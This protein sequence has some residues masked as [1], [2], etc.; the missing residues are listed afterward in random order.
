V[1]QLESM[2]LLQAEG[3]SKLFGELK[4]LQGVDLEVKTG[5][6]HALLGHP[7]AGK[8]TLLNV[9]GGVYAPDSGRLLLEGK[10]VNFS[11]PDDAL[12]AGI[13]MVHQ[14]PAVVLPDLDVSE[15]IFQGQE[16]TA[17]FDSDAGRE[18]YERSERLLVELKLS[19]SPRIR[20]SML[21]V[22]A[23]QMI[24]IAKA[25]SHASKLL[26]LDEPTS[27]LTAR[28]Q[29]RLFELIESLKGRGMSV[30]YATRRA[31]E[32]SEIADTVTV[33][34]EGRLV[35]TMLA[36]EMDDSTLVDS[37]G[38][39]S[40]TDTVAS[41]SPQDEVGF[42]V[43]GLSS[44]EAS[45]WDIVFSARRGEILGLAGMLG[46]GPEKLFEC[47]YGVR[48][49][50]HGLIRVRGREVRPNS[51]AEAM[52]VGITLLPEKRQPVSILS[53]IS[54][55]RNAVL[56]SIRDLFHRVSGP[57]RE[58]RGRGQTEE[59]A[60]PFNEKRSSA[61]EEIQIF[62]G[63][64]REKVVPTDQPMRHPLVL[65]LDDPTAGIDDAAKTEIHSLI[66]ALAEEGVTIILS[67]SEFPELLGLCHRILV[68]RNG[69][70]V[71][72]VDPSSATEDSVVA[73]TTGVD[74]TRP[75]DEPSLITETRFPP[76]WDP[77]PFGWGTQP[78]ADNPDDAIKWW[79]ARIEDSAVPE[80][81]PSVVLTVDE[82][83]ELKA[84]KPKV[85]HAW[86]D[87]SVPAIGGWNKFWKKGVS[88]WADSVVV[89]DNHANPDRLR[90]GAQFL[91]EQDLLVAGT[92]SFDWIR[93]SE[94]M[95]L[96]HAAKIATTG[97]ATSP[98]AYYPPT[99]TCMTDN[100]SE[101]RKL[102]LPTAQLLRGKGYSSVDAVWL[103]EAHPSWFSISRQIGFKEGLNDPKVQE[104]CK[105]NIIETKPVLED[106]DAEATATAA[107]EKHP[108]IHLL[109]MLAHQFKGA[110]A[111]VRNAGRRD[112]WVV[113]SDLDEG[114]A[115]TL[116]HGAWPVL[117][118]Y[119][120][121]ISGSGYA[122]ANVMGKI[123]LGK[124][125]PL[126][127][128]SKGTVVTSANVREASAH[129]WGGEPLPWQ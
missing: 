44:S 49:F 64:S 124:R 92:L 40:A 9:F 84:M 74:T 93:S 112:V 98:S 38:A 127:V 106:A 52:E 42:E 94:S 61:E 123:L 115:L 65:L 100:I 101:Y 3:L 6:I 34:R 59:A 63:G 7:G 110:A 85:G 17:K 126:I 45:V 39:Q 19:L 82:I 13:S 71:Q 54:G 80:D 120:L 18:L 41:L 68:F 56:E 50:D 116:L 35:A 76:R 28:E 5:S 26:I 43:V 67:S 69:R 97:V 75:A 119:S 8:T 21:S 107:L 10:A 23:R 111:A 90:A 91:I 118:T 86:Y 121:P 37:Y 53:E 1:N 117:I 12:R 83:K 122:D 20:C 47:L 66:R 99:C 79:L 48:P 95:R 81:D 24:E 14:E 30:L 89:Y 105:I 15:R 27:A 78:I 2:A 128:L 125:V 4:V 70:I 51:P 102:V 73:M 60:K 33:L 25:V 114:T 36:R 113:A 62:T 103:V 109:I 88:A 16:A 104:I 87:L 29:R 57:G 55:W 46:S 22:R 11:S 77:Y 58:G 32:I 72:E 129:D 108:N 31:G 96:F